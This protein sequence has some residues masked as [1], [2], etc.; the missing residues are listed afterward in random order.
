MDK[1]AQYDLSRK[2]IYFIVVL[3]FLAIMFLLLNSTFK[4]L[5]LRVLT[6]T[7]K[8]SHRVLMNEMVFSPHCFAYVDPET[9]RAYPGVIDLA[10]FNDANL[11]SP[12]GKYYKGKFTVYLVRDK[13]NY[14]NTV[15]GYH[16]ASVVNDFSEKLLKVGNPDAKYENYF[17]MPVFVK[18]RDKIERGVLVVGYAQ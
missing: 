3:F 11:Y 15:Y 1:R 10:R 8:M 2:V 5:D 4:T 17:R 6:A 16:Y 7:E 13:P 14:P 18:D 9:Q 12:C